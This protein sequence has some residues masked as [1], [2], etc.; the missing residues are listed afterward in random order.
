MV[1][2][3]AQSGAS[4]VVASRKLDACE[5]VASQITERF[6]RDA[7]AVAANVSNWDD[8]DAL[9]EAAYERFG[10]VDVLVNNAGMSPLYP[11]LD[12]VSEALYNK[13]LA[14]NLKGPFRLSALVGTRMVAG[15]GGSIINIAGARCPPVRDGQG[16]ARSSHLRSYACFR[17]EGSG[18][19]DP[20][21][22]VPHRYFEGVGRHL[23]R[24]GDGS[25]SDAARPDRRA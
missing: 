14:T 5:A 15:E 22:R 20:L 11:A 23:A 18:E 25:G 1:H 4:V 16:G 2:A 6:G 21:R 7:L 9:A 3:F 10:K 12:Q 24:G 13:V 19:H 17:P 8:C